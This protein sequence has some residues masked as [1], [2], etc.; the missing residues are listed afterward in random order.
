MAGTFGR[1]KSL[2]NRAIVDRGDV[3]RDWAES[4]LSQAKINSL[5]DALFTRED[6]EISKALDRVKRLIEELGLR[7]GKEARILAALEAERPSK[8]RG[9]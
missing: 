9:D 5:E 2:V 6:R 1:R 4:E 7:D 3:V 8:R